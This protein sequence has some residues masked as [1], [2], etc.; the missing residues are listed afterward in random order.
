[1]KAA[2]FSALVF[3]GSGHLYLKRYVIGFV[4]VVVSVVAL[5]V[6][7]STALEVAQVVSAEMLNGEITLDT[8]SISAEITRQRANSGSR[9]ADISSYLLLA[10]WLVGIVDSFRAGRQEDRRD[11]TRDSKS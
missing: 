6:L 4:L 2:L 11:R 1:M 7:L 9:F 8:E 5:Y 3:P 10:C